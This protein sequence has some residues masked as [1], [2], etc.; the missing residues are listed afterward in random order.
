MNSEERVEK[1]ARLLARYRGRG[2][3]ETLP[4]NERAWFSWITKNFSKPLA[5]MSWWGLWRLSPKRV[6]LTVVMGAQR[7]R[8]TRMT[9]GVSD[10]TGTATRYL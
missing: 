7:T 10:G 6:W 4:D 3:W 9:L 1:A 8:K 2:P 5:L